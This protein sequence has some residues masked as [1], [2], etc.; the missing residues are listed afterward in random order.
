MACGQLSTNRRENRAGNAQN[1]HRSESMAPR[2]FPMQ[3]RVRSSCRARVWVRT[4]SPVWAEHWGVKP[5]LRPLFP[6]FSLADPWRKIP[7][8]KRLKSARISRVSAVSAGVATQHRPFPYEIPCIFPAKQG[9]GGA[10]PAAD[11]QHS[12]LTLLGK[13]CPPESAP[14]PH[15]ISSHSA[16]LRQRWRV[17]TPV[18]ARHR[19]RCSTIGRR[20]K[21]GRATGLRAPCRLFP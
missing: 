1:A 10:N 16:F 18:P 5:S 14:Q 2:S 7:V 21:P 19:S 15:P 12:Q 9:I 17:Q 4:R 6:F 8:P 20:R 13:R 11:C 3:R